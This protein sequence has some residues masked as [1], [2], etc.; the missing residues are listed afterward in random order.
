MNFT[1]HTL[2]LSQ[3]SSSPTSKCM[4]PHHNF[5]P[6][7]LIDF[8]TLQKYS[9]QRCRRAVAE[10]YS[11]STTPFAVRLRGGFDVGDA[12]LRS[13]GSYPCSAAGS[14]SDHSTV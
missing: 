14:A 1:S 2:K 10:S 13:M 11:G 7:P 3:Q 4:S 8:F 12:V 9:V 6:S 5:Q